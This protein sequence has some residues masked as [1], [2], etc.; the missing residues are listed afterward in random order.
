MG[1]FDHEWIIKLWFWQRPYY[2][3]FVGIDPSEIPRWQ[4]TWHLSRYSA[5]KVIKGNPYHHA[6]P[7]TRVNRQFPVKLEMPQ[8]RKCRGFDVPSTGDASMS[9]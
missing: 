7:N 5:A 3:Q 8:G 9:A 4:R 6:A 1:R 2:W